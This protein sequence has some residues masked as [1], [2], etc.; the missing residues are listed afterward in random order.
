M[1]NAD[2]SEINLIKCVTLYKSWIWVVTLHS[3]FVSLTAC[4]KV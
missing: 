1:T 4:M 2:V 3:M